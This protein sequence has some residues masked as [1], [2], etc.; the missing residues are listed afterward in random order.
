MML[1]VCLT[2]LP[3]CKLPTHFVQCYTE[4][5]NLIFSDFNNAITGF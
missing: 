1:L 3:V 2:E 5:R 4:G